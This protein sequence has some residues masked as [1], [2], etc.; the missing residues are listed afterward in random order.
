LHILRRS[1]LIIAIIVLATAAAFSPVVE[2]GFVNYDDDKHILA[3]PRFNPPALKSTLAYWTDRGFFGL[4]IPVTYTAWTVVAQIA[5]RGDAFSP[6][7][8]HGANL[9]VHACNA[10]LVYFIL[11]RLVRSAP[12]PAML[13]ALLFALHPLQ[14]EP[15]AWVSGFRDVFGGLLALWAILRYLDF[16]DASEPVARRIAYFIAALVFALALLSKPT[17]VVVPLILVVIATLI[18]RRPS[19]ASIVPLAPLVVMSLLAV[20]WARF[21]QPSILLSNPVDLVARPLVAADSVSFYLNKLV[22]PTKLIPDYGRHGFAG[23]L[24]FAPAAILVTLILLRRRASLL[25]AS[26]LILLAALL[27][28][29]GLVP[30][31]FQE[32]SNVADRYMYLPMFGAALALA[33]VV[34]RFDG[35]AM[36]TVVCAVLIAF[37]TLSFHQTKIWR[38][39]QTLFARTLEVNP[40]SWLACNNLGAEAADPAAAEQLLRRS[41]ALKPDYAEARINLGAVLAEQGQLAEAIEQFEIAIRLRPDLPE[42]QANLA[43]ARRARDLPPASR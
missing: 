4:Y 9:L 36:R 22:W 29:L 14:V 2:C 12:W 28:V 7:V 8:F 26:Y 15:V 13:G 27:P 16:L 35:I 6:A 25:L 40:R 3:N 20:A 42:A 24:V 33:A 11:R 10:I 30:F 17:A 37:G 5:R 19:R 1:W 43:R 18:R 34:S 41:V 31:D 21:A 32:I 39:T 23:F 38:N